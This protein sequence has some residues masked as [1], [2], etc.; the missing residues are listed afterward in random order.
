MF[1]GGR[2]VFVAGNAMHVPL[3]YSARMSYVNADI[4]RWMF[5]S[6]Q[7]AHGSVAA[8]K[9]LQDFSLPSTLLQ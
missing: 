3:Q 7:S 6:L 2:L 1:V 8:A 9:N 5:N 4:I